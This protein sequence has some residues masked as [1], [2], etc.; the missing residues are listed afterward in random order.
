MWV[1]KCS[2]GLVPEA[3]KPQM[4]HS[5]SMKYF[6]RGRIRF[7][8]FF[9]AQMSLRSFS[10]FFRSKRSF[11]LGL[12][13][14]DRDRVSGPNCLLLS[15]IWDMVSCGMVFGKDRVAHSS[16]SPS[17]E[18]LR[19]GH[20]PWAQTKPG[21]LSHSVDNSFEMSVHG[22]YFLAR[23][24]VSTEYCNPVLGSVMRHVSTLIGSPNSDGTLSEGG[25]AEASFNGVIRATTRITDILYGKHKNTRRSYFHTVGGKNSEAYSKSL[26]QFDTLIIQLLTTKLK[27][28]INFIYD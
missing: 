24:V 9:R 1:D 3:M 23:T 19:T 16:L 20:F 11:R 7:W 2:T 10:I 14:G 4:R 13:T 12:L 25:F 8:D 5:P 15:G 6:R 18:R 21:T 26:S 27:G 22:S 17:A 28:N